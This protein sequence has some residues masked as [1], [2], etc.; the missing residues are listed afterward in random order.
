LLGAIPFEV[1]AKYA[2]ELA[3][4]NLVRAGALLK[5]TG[6]GQIVAHLQE[7]GAAQQ[8]LNSVVGS[9]FSPIQALNAPAA[10][11]SNIQLVQ[12]KAM[13]QGLQILQFANLGATLTGIGVSAIGFAL[14]SR[15]LNGLRDQVSNIEGAVRTGFIEIH[16]REIRTQYSL[17][18]GLFKQADQAQALSSPSGEWRRISSALAD[19]GAYFRGELTHLL[20]G[21]RFEI[22]LFEMLTRSL[23]LSNAG[24]IECLMLAGELPA[25]QKVS[26]DIAADYN[27]LFD[28][29]TPTQLAHKSALNFKDSDVPVEHLIKQ[30]MPGM[31]DLVESIRDTQDVAASKPYLIDTLMNRGIDGPSY[32]EVIKNESVEPILLLDVSTEQ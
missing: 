12:L 17:L 5:D 9:P 13:M 14:M 32:M 4:G 6:S 28:P 3:A 31:R 11:A 27:N 23:A 19:S 7:T 16:A 20:Q 30:H 24:R 18:E 10:I 25:A 2:G 22:D 8:V 15:K 21:D 29:L 26:G 1:P